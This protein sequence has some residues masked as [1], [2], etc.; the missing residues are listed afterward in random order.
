MIFDIELINFIIKI[1]QKY[2]SEN[3]YRR[4]KKR[5]PYRKTIDLLEK[6]FFPSKNMSLHS[7]KINTQDSQYIQT[8]V[9]RHKNKRIKIIEKYISENTFR[10]KKKISYRKTIDLLEKLFFPSE[11]MCLHSVKINNEYTQYIQYVLNRHKNKRHLKCDY[12]NFSF[13]YMIHTKHFFIAQTELWIPPLWDNPT[14]Y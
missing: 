10:C 14:F 12:C 8:V 5:I 3:I 2:I 1:I 7:V 11:K 9:K 13:N 4:K 6:L